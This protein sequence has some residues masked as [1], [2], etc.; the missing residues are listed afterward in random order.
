MKLLNL[1]NRY[2]DIA[3][4][5]RSKRKKRNT[6]INF[7]RREMEFIIINMDYRLLQYNALNVFLGGQFF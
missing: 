4:Y 5:N 3:E 7:N 1:T 6:P 2:F